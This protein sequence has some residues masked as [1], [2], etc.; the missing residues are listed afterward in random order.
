MFKKFPFYKQLD[1]MDCGP[2]CLKIITAYYGRN[3]SRDLLRERSFLTQT[4]VSLNGISQAAESIG[5]QTLML[6]CNIKMLEEEVP[7]PVIAHWRERHFIVIYKVDNYYVYTSDPAHGLLKYKKQEFLNGWL[8]TNTEPTIDAEGIILALE[9]TPDFYNLDSKNHGEKEN[10]IGFLY[11]YFKPY[12]YLILQLFIGLLIGSLIQLMMPF[13]TQSVVDIGIK[14]NNLHFVY[15]VL[16]SQLVLFFSQTFNGALRSW[17][18]LHITSRINLNLLSAFLVKLMKLPIS[19][20]DSKSIGDLLQRIQ[21]NSRIQNFLS[22]TTLNVLFSFFNL[23]IFGAVLLYYNV[24]IFFIFFTCSVL[25]TFWVILFLKRRKDLDYK[26]FDQASG[27]Q[28]S[29]MQLLQGMQ[30]IRLNNSEKRRRWEWEAIQIKLFKLS[31]KSLSLSQTQEIG[32][33]F[34]LQLM[35][36][37][38]IFYAAKQVIIG[39]FTL[40]VMLSIQYII[41]QL[42]SP[43]NGIIGFIQSYQDAKISLERL[44]E[45]HNIDDEANFDIQNVTELSKNN[46]IHI[47]NLYFQYGAKTKN[48][49]LQDINLIIPENKVTAIVGV[50]GSGKSTLIKLLLKF[51]TPNQGQ[52]MIGGI[53]LKN[54]H[55]DF[56]RKNVGTVMQDGYLFADTISRNITESDSDGLMNKEKLINAINL[57][58]LGE[59]V[60]G[61]PNGFKTRIG[62]SG[63]N[64]SGGQRQRVFIARAVYKDPKFLFFDEATSSLDA[65]N[66]SLIMK[67]LES[68][69]K[70]RTVV[71]VAHR[72]STV[73]NADQIVV[74]DKG[75]IVEIGNH[76][77]LVNSK[78]H[79]YTLIKNQLEL[80]NT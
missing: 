53:D 29:T 10:S 77:D 69:Y 48:W 46:D 56:W 31:I 55:T 57:A 3:I 9:A 42:M 8:P 43:V 40:G 19:Y 75:K 6:Q 74:L 30:E 79:Y 26:K 76:N 54:I 4:G 7:L 20:F 63:L 38:I 70:N 68:F 47:K 36:I 62:S 71:I 17:I 1:Q 28:S 37:L 14:T 5:I 67:N 32:S 58:N 66:E 59:F 24:T 34:I 41:G 22:S 52:I 72:L 25:N 27:N 51:Y 21:D 11:Q 80:G 39:G 35:N 50:S 61:L 45:I 49:V 18:L 64:I 33:S 44:G 13:L 23:I 16:L 78:G 65:N 2:T 73:K 15:L 12:K 60:D